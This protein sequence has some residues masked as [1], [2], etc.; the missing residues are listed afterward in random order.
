MKSMVLYDSVYGNTEKV[1]RAIAAVLAQAGDVEIQPVSAVT[2]EQLS[3]LD[4]LVVGSPT[5]AFGPIQA[6]KDFLKSLKGKSLEG[7]K[8]AAFDT[9]MDVKV[10]KSAVLT[11]MAG[12]FGYAAEKI[13]KG[14]KSA[15][16]VEAI[17][18][19]GF[20]VTGN[21]GPLTEG[22]LERAVAWAH[23]VLKNL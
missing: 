21:E 5:Q 13:G 6:T 16:G 11:F 3:G 8:V 1:A 2:A 23:D 7:V 9:R 20:F 18:P 19:A 12:I 14:L 22:E 17:A 15:G 10:V 4:L